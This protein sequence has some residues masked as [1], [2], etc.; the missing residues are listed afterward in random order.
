MEII[1]KKEILGGAPVQ[2]SE[3]KGK[4][5]IELLPKDKK[6]TLKSLIA[7]IKPENLH[8]ET[9]WGSASGKEAW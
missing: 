9:D 7:Q 1:T 4:I 8:N 6:E 3:H 2:V 5:V